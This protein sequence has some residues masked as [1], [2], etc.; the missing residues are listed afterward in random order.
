[1]VAGMSGGGEV[2]GGLPVAHRG[3]EVA[4]DLFQLAD[5]RVQGRRE[6]GVLGGVF[7]DGGDQGGDDRG[8]G[9]AQGRGR[10]WYHG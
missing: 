5:G 2:A 10:G 3:I 9:L 1:M 4:G 6:H 7:G 8:E